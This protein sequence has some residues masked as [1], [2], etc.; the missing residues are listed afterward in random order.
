VLH[1]LMLKGTVYNTLIFFWVVVEYSVHRKYRIH[2][3]SS[4][5]NVFRMGSTELQT[6]AEYQ[7]VV[8]S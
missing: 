8:E 3:E 4:A 7:A 1:F 5:Q 2:M 6:L